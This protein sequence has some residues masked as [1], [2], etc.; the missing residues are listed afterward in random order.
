MK[1][2]NKKDDH[3]KET[4]N[5]N[6]MFEKVKSAD[7]PFEKYKKLELENEA[8]KDAIVKLTLKVMGLERQLHPDVW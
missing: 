6:T 1:N 5:L 3:T 8:L 2:I 4:N 7:V